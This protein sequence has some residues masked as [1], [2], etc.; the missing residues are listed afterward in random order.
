V[1]VYPFIE[2][3]K[4]NSSSRAVSGGKS[5]G[6][7]GRARGNVKR[8]C[9]LLQVSRSAYYAHAAAQAAGG[10]TRQQDD[11][12]LLARIRHHHVASKG[13]YGAPRVHA[14]LL[15]EG[16]RH[17][18]KRVAR[19]M[20]GAGLVGKHRR[21]TQR[22]TIPDPAAPAR[23]DLIGRDFTTEPPWVARRVVGYATSGTGA[24]V[25]AWR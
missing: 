4:Q 1:N 21:R 5:D 10:T 20:R 23:A 6:S 9:E 14:D 17:G 2:A 19:L 15:D 8:A 7:S 12:Q 18:R 13:R 24:S 11:A 22:T 3:E 25:V 16:R